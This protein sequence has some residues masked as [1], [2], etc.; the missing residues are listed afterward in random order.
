MKEK[1]Y[2]LNAKNARQLEKPNDFLLEF[3]WNRTVQ[4][5]V[6]KFFLQIRDNMRH[7]QITSI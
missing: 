7:R 1:L 5:I 4:K 3:L 2:R 6:S